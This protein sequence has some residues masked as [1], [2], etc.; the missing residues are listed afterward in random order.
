M[1][2]VIFFAAGL[3]AFSAGCG[4]ATRSEVAAPPEVAPAAAPQEAAPDQPE[5]AS[6]EGIVPALLGVEQAGVSS[7][8]IPVSDV[9]GTSTHAIPGDDLVEPYLSRSR[10]GSF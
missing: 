4:T 9:S 7:L 1:R 3:A 8:S 10:G 2:W 6:G 5:T